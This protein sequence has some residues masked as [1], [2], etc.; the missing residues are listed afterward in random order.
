MINKL[1]KKREVSKKREVE[2]KEIR[3]NILN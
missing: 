3:I 1:K 2:K